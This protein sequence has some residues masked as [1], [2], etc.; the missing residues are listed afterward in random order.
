M[1]NPQAQFENDHFH[2]PEP[3]EPEHRLLFASRE[4][5]EDWCEWLEGLYEAVK[6]EMKEG[7]F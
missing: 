1:N 6:V 4:E 7:D 3:V 2:L 5:E